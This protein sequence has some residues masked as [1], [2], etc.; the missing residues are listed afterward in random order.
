M[1]LLRIRPLKVLL[2]SSLGVTIPLSAQAGGPVH[3]AKATAMGTAFVALADDPSAILHNPAG[4][5]QIHGVNLYAGN[6]V[7]IPSSK[8]ISL[9]GEDGETKSKLFF[10][11]HVYLSTDLG[12]DNMALGIGVFS[13][14]GI[15]GRFWE[16][17][18][19]TRYIS[20]KSTIATVAANPTMAWRICPSLSVGFGLFYLHAFNTAEKK[21]DQSVFGWS[22][23]TFSTE[24][25]GG[26]WGYDFGLLFKPSES[27]SLGFAYRSHVKIDQHGHARLK[28]IAAPLQPLFGGSEYRTRVDTAVDFPELMTFGLAYKIRKD[29][30]IVL[31]AEFGNWSRFDQQELDFENEVP[32]A[33]FRDIRVDLD[34]H[35][36]WILKVGF[37]YQTGEL[38]YLRWGY[39]FGESPVPDKSLSPANPDSD[40][41]N[42]SVG[43]GKTMGRWNLDAFYNIGLFEKRKVHNQILSGAYENQTHYVG[44]SLD[45]S[46]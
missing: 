1:R 27:L 12:T 19:P 32:S 2:V 17:G 18:S 45:I 4:L 26:G 9:T 13:P 41:H 33:G 22:E 28:N 14:F 21:I 39:C 5:V 44:F 10:P 24:A 35:D 31:E 7:V 37:Q 40:Q 8:Y 38:T 42:I 43:F 36:A 23:G 6:T 16:S 25:D 3:G 11:P 15:G 30:T 46:F 29:F 34:W 20:T